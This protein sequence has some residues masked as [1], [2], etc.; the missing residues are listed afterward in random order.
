MRIGSATTRWLALA[1]ASSSARAFYLPGAAPKDYAEGEP[2]PVY[3]NALT[4]VI[5][6]NA[7]LKSMMNYDYYNPGFNFCTP[8]EGIVK[9]SESLGSILFGDRIFNSPYNIRMRQNASCTIL[10]KSSLSTEQATF[11]NERINEDQAINWLVDGLPASELKQDPKSGE[12]FYDM[13]FNLGNDDD[14]YAEKPLLNNHYDIRMEYHETANGKFRVVGVLVWP[15]SLDTPSSGQPTCDTQSANPPHLSVSSTKKNEFYY[16]YSVTWTKS[17]TPWATRWDNYLHIFDPKIH[18]FS[19]INSIVIVVF[20]CV[21]VSMILL[22]TV[23]K[24]ISR[25]N[26]MDLSED[27]QEDFGWK[28][29][30]GEV[31][32]QPR[33]P[34]ALSVLAGNGAQL[35]AMAGITLGTIISS[36]L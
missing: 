22:R 35:A 31:F 32:R 9:Q 29:V 1:L 27:I 19:L 11:M 30:H 8:E 36:S 34:M 15:F 18:W 7:K 13:G 33:Y 3:V 23:S 16:T 2:V 24:D 26:A 5:A 6:S 14:E 10:C 12:L 28:L 17:D 25:Y 20:L 4:P 21:M